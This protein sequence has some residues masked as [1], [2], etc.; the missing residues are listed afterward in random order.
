M[1]NIGKIINYDGC[2]GFIIDNDGKKYILSKNNILYSNPQNGDLVTFKIEKF[3]TVEVEEYIAT[4][5]LKVLF[6]SNISEN[7]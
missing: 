2:S 7:N 4:F 6:S 5:V 1:K 3:K